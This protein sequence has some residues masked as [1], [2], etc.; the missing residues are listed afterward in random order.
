[1]ERSWGN[2]PMVGELWMV[3]W[4]EWA[5]PLWLQ[6]CVSFKSGWKKEDREERTSGYEVSTW[7]CSLR[8]MI[9][10]YELK[11]TWIRVGRAPTLLLIVLCW[12]FLTLLWLLRHRSGPIS[13]LDSIDLLGLPL[14]RCYRRTQRCKSCIG[15]S[16][17]ESF[18]TRE[19]FS[20]IRG[21]LFPFCSLLLSQTSNSGSISHHSS[22]LYFYCLFCN[23]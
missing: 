7:I 4:L 16:Q 15:D 10:S 1:M 17:R 19:V 23:S 22:K 21:P 9:R 8:G 11:R 3:V 6:Q 14:W 18:G 12:I 2:S 13:S 5:Y 20:L